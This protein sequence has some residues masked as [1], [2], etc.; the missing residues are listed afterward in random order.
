MLSHTCARTPITHLDLV[1]AVAGHICCLIPE[2]IPL[3]AVRE[4]VPDAGPFAML[5]P[6]A[7]SLEGGT[8]HTPGEACR[9]RPQA[10]P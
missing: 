3:P 8:A 7:L 1:V 10:G 5:V 9:G 4:G 6:G 2:H